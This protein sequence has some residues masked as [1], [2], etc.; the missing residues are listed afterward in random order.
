MVISVS[1]YYIPP[2]HIN[3]PPLAFQV[4]SLIDSYMIWIGIME[5]TAEN[6]HAAASNGRLAQEW[7][8]AMPSTHSSI[9]SPGTSLYRA[10]NA[11]IALPMAQR[12]AR[13]FKI[14]VFLS[15]DLPPAF[16]TM[17][18][19]VRLTLEVEKRAIEILK[20][21]ESNGLT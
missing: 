21:L 1:T 5:G 20:S 15:I 3:S 12:L 14:Q 6:V 16:T 9:P 13:R 8:C 4:T 7:A 11:D 19:N 2:I 17:G 10:S 18:E